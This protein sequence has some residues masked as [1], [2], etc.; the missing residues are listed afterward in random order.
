[1]KMIKDAGAESNIA[2]HYTSPL[3]LANLTLCTN[4]LK[5]KISDEQ[6]EQLSF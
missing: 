1:M 5:D 3:Y 4:E 6:K 2:S